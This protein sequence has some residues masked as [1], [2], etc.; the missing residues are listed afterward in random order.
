MNSSSRLLLVEDEALVAED[1]QQQLSG[2]GYVV[3]GWAV[4]AEE[5]LELA[6]KHRPDL[7]LSDIQIQGPRDGVAAAEA[8]QQE[9][10]TPVVFLTALADESTLQRAKLTAPFGYIVKPCT[11][12]GLRTA[13]EVALERSRLEQR[14]HRAERLL[15]ATLRSIGDA[16]ITTDK[17]GTV[18]FM[19]R[20]AEAITGF[21]AE[22]CLGRDL[23]TV[24]LAFNPAT[25][26]TIESPVIA[27]VKQGETI[28]LERDKTLIAFGGARIPIDESCAPIRNEHDQIVGGILVF[29]DVTERRRQEQERERLIKELQ[30]ALA[31]VKTL[32]R[33]LPICAWCK[34]VRADDGYWQSV[35]A[36]ITSHTQAEFTHGICP[37]CFEKQ[38]RRA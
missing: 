23:A 2:L 29:R 5:A 15:D 19:N 14:M 6:L 24:F 34:K 32:T 4:T 26:E 21:D 10:S 25:G 35:E 17:S 38:M 7:V 3:V 13:I 28:K 33:L 36:Y 12:V 27:A 31:K 30:S 9:L 8:I 1:L 20:V 16:V 37:V 11:K 22:D 18:T